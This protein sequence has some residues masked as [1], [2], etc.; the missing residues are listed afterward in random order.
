MIEAVENS[1]NSK[2][3][4]KNS[5]FD[6]QLSNNVWY[7]FGLGIYSICLCERVRTKPVSLGKI[8]EFI[9]NKDVYLKT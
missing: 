2:M 1:L 6:S 3:R 4:A 9:N 8:S 5:G 7:E